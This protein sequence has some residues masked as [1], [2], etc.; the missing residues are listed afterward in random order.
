M[1]LN[2]IAI[3]AITNKMWII[4]PALKPKKPMAQKITSITAIVYNKFP[5]AYIYIFLI[6]S[7]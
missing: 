3:I 2:S 5:M 1:I 7:E 6:K 4:P